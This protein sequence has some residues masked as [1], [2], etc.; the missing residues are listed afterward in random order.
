MKNK[1]AKQM[2]VDVTLKGRKAIWHGE[3]SE[4]HA[5]KSVEQ[6]NDHYGMDEGGEVIT[7]NW[8]YWWQMQL[9][10][11]G[12]KMVGKPAIGRDGTVI[13]HYELLPLVCAV[14]GNADDVCQVST[15]YN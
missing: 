8:H 9:C 10:E 2:I 13:P 6:I 15:S 4:V 14:Y 3:E 7:S 5:A 12:D 1:R 11:I